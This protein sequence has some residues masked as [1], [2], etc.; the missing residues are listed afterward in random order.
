MQ[1]VN[2][3]TV[4]LYKNGTEISCTYSVEDIY[5]KV[6]TITPTEGLLQ[7]KDYEV[8]I[9][10]VGAYDSVAGS[11]SGISYTFSTEKGE[12]F[13]LAELEA[14]EGGIV[15]TLY[16]NTDSNASFITIGV[17]KNA[18]GQIIEINVGTSGTV[19]ANDN[20]SISVE[21]A[22]AASYEL[23]VWDS[24]TSMKPLVKKNILV[25]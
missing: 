8:L 6:V 9:S 17:G 2:S 21:M 22:T 4:K 13:T 23:F 25:L 24:L 12:D 3:N 19:Q 5:K 1:T 7:N 16:N 20:T 15:S 14:V 10:G 18:D 11:V